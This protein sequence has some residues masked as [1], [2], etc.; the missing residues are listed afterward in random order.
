MKKTM[1]IVAALLLAFGLF[2][3]GEQAASPDVEEE[4]SETEN[5]VVEENTD[6]S[7]EID[8]DI[9]A[10]L[11]FGTW[12]ADAAAL[13]DELDLEGRFQ[14]L[15][16]NV[17]LEIEEFKDDTEYFNAMKIRAS[18][19]ELPDIM[20]NETVTLANFVEYLYD[21]ND[22]EA[23]SNNLLAEGYAIDGK[24]YGLPEKRQ[25]E[26]VLFWRDMFD[27]AGVDVPQ[28]WSE[29]VDVSNKLQEYYES[30]DSFMAIALGAKDEWP[31]YPLVENMPS[32]LN[33]N[34]QYWNEM[35]YQDNAFAEGTDIYTAYQKIYDFFKTGDFGKDPLGLGYDQAFSIFMQ[36]GAAMAM[37]SPIGLTGIYSA[38]IDTTG[39]ESFYLPFRDDES[40]PLYVPV[41]GD[42]LMGITKSTQNYDLAKAFVEFYFSDAWY[43]DYI[44]ALSSA[45]TMGNFEKELDPVLES[46]NENSHGVEIYTYDGG[47]KDFQAL[48]TET[49][50]DYKK[51]G[52]EMFT[53]SFDFE[54]AMGDLNT[55]WENARESLGYK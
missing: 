5:V 11:T 12:D 37:D 52:A 38:G 20:F 47:N 55:A 40:D 10:T 49:K 51:L 25:E 9:K 46:A 2:G 6:S 7:E 27:E 19:E 30:D 33:G 14:E 41:R 21:L 4:A 36:K 53:D 22:L 44:S 16:P 34:G 8:T 15:Y 28:T 24:V 29:F 1:A 50:F 3:C 43:P 13:Y 18:A 48:V 45:S 26:Y 17:S 23:T 35:V 39:L 54:K 32:G 42:F 31:I